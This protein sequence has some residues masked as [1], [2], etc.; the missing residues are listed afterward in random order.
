M[1][2]VLFSHSNPYA[3]HRNAET[4]S[5]LFYIDSEDP[6]SKRGKLSDTRQSCS[7]ILRQKPEMEIERDK[8]TG[9]I[10]WD[11]SYMLSLY[12]NSLERWR[13]WFPSRG[14][15]ATPRVVELGAGTGLVSIAAFLASRGRSKVVSTDLEECIQL[16]RDNVRV[17]TDKL[18]SELGFRD[19]ETIETTA[20][21]CEPSGI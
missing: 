15:D 7:V 5:F 2:V 12:I 18:K 3:D 17:N 1:A 14:N 21:S 9:F 6:S 4:R 8:N 11:G 10:V 13:T 16:L 20:L 19:T